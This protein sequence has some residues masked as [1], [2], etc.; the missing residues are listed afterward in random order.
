MHHVTSL[1]AK[2]Y[3]KGAYHACLGVTCDLHFWQNDQD[4]L[5]ATAVT[6]WWNRY[7]NE[8]QHRKFTLENFFILPLLM[9]L[10]PET[11]LSLSVLISPVLPSNL[12][13]SL[14][15]YL[16][17]SSLH[18]YLSLSFPPLSLS[19]SPVCLSLSPKKKKKKK[20]KK[21][22]EEEEEEEEKEE[23]RLASGLVF[24]PKNRKQN[25]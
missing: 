6:R 20:K 24:K 12:S 7:R 16:S 9:G 8:S 5:R 4:L 10:E 17:T 3:T 23:A 15:L 13:L 18:P 25:T 19:L 14:P 21:K 11:F 1:H 2:L 22:E